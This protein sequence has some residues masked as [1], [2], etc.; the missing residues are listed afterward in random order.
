MKQIIVNILIIA[1]GLS[2]TDSSAQSLPELINTA[3]QNNYQI[4]IVRNQ[5]EIASNNNVIGNTGQLPSL[6][7]DGAAANS[8]NSTQQVFSDESIRE[9]SNARNSSINFALLANWTLF[10]GFRVYAKRDQLAYLDQFGQVNSKFYIEQTVSDIVT[11]YYQLIYEKELLDNLKQSLSISSFRYKIEKKKREVGSGQ[12]IDFGQALVDYQSDSI[13]YLAQENEIKSLM[14]E[15]NRVLNIDLENEILISND[16]ITIAPMPQRDSLLGLVEAN[17]YQLELK[18]LEE[19]V[20]ESVVRM[21]KADRYPKIDLFG[22]YR[23]SKSFAEVGF[24]QSNRNYGPT[25]G[26]T[27]SYNLYK[28]GAVNREI[29]NTRI[30]AENQTL[31]REEVNTNLDADVLHLYTQYQSVMDRIA[32]AVSNVEAMNRVYIV[33]AQQLQSG[34]INGYDF[35][36]TQQSLLRAEVTL[37]NLRYTLKAIEINLNRLSGRVL[38][39]YM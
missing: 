35:R 25:F 17:N 1:L 27:I 5:S 3:L 4:N 20:S 19:L 12:A 26:V 21:A 36:L 10:D 13:L 31:E 16:S 32:L 22:G 34:A 29:K 30:I 23:Y 18:R 37:L 14:I 33:A 2:F 28:G 7:L 6:S 38:S 11:A 24:I 39:S 9:G 8:Y 15:I